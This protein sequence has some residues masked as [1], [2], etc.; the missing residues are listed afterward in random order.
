MNNNINDNDNNANIYSCAPHYQAA[1]DVGGHISMMKEET[2]SRC[3]WPHHHDAD[4]H[5]TL[6]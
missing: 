6:K 3:R 1:G 2:A 5:K 4:D